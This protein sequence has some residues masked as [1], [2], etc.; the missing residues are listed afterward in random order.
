[1]GYDGA[2]LGDVLAEQDACLNIAQRLPCTNFYRDVVAA[3][4]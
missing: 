3:L 4:T 2:V 1:M